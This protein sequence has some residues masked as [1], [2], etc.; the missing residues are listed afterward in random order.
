VTQKSLEWIVSALQRSEENIAK[1]PN[2]Q[3]QIEE[4]G[5]VLLF[6]LQLFSL[7]VHASL[8]LFVSL[9]CSEILFIIL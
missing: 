1:L 4:D 8:W 2:I 7:V 9:K 5:R 3:E 6:I